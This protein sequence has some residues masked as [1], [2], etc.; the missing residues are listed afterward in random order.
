M[1]IVTIKELLDRAQ[2][3]EGKLERCYAEIRDT[4]TDNGVRLL[5]YYLARHRRHL[6]Q[7]LSEL[8]VHERSRVSKVQ[9]KYDVDF[10]PEHDFAAIEV[11]DTG[12]HASELLDHA[13]RYDAQLIGLYRS[14]LEQ[15]IGEEASELLEALIRL[16]E[17]DTVML[18]KMLAMNYF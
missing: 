6:D 18:K 1:A 3:F 11:P 15:P 10:H 14:I 2:D 17:K 7:A 12:I 5:T 8:D 16:E 4:T 9:V 13:I